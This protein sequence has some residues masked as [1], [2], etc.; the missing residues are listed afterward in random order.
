M[1]EQIVWIGSGVCELM[2]TAGVLDAPVDACGD[3]PNMLSFGV[4]VVVLGGIA[5][6]ML[7]VMGRGIRPR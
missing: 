3:H 5:A 6:V 1:E 7:S 2:H 4:M